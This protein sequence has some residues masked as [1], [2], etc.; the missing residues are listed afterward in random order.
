MYPNDEWYDELEQ[1]QERHALEDLAAERKQQML[2]A[3]RTRAETMAEAIVVINKLLV[4][5]E[6]IA[7]GYER[8]QKASANPHDWTIDHRTGQCARAA[9]ASAHE[10][11]TQMRQGG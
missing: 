6:S 3:V 7:S 11:L 8:E 5:C 1:R 9:A 4:V 10:F 2:N